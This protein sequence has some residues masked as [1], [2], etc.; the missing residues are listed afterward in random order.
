MDD[1]ISN[2]IIIVL[3]VFVKPAGIIIVINCSVISIIKLRAATR[4]RL[5]MRESQNPIN[6]PD[7]KVTRLRHLCPSGRCR[8]AEHVLPARVSPVQ[9]VPQN[10]PRLLQYPVRTVGPQLISQLLCIFSTEFQVSYH[11]DA[12]VPS[13]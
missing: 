5:E 4:K 12:D 1:E 10:L 7:S 8:C 6:Q 2:S 11:S 3:T 9:K 13:L